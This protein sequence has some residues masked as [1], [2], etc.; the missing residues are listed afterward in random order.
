MVFAETYA[1]YGCVDV[2]VEGEPFK[3]QF[4][5]FELFDHFN[6]C[7]FCI[8][9]ICKEYDEEFRALSCFFCAFLDIV[10]ANYKI[11]I[12][13]NFLAVDSM[14]HLFFGFNLFGIK[15]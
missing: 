8:L 12:A 3:F 15:L 5:I 6:S 10:E 2:L 1:V 7:I 11:G 13:I 14:V 9:T 4:Q